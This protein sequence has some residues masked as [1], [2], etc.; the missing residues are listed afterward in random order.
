MQ[1]KKIEKKNFE[2][3]KTKKEG[4]IIIMTSFQSLLPP[5]STISLSPLALDVNVLLLY[6]CDLFL[7]TKFLFFLIDYF[8]NVVFDY[9]I[10]KQIRFHL[11]FFYLKK[12]FKYF[13]CVFRTRMQWL[14][15]NCKMFCL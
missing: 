14:S 15:T 9:Y 5:L 1:E 12:L 6:L 7:N 13:L 4:F 8:Y 10:C 2:N 11:L 3:E